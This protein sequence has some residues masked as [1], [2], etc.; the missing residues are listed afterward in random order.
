MGSFALTSRRETR[1]PLAG[2]YAAAVGLALLALCPFIVLSTAGQ[3]LNEHV[4]ADLHTS[5]FGVQLADGLANDRP[6]TAFGGEKASGLGRFGGDWAIE[7]FTTDHWISVQH[8]ART[9]P[10]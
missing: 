6:N 2:N 10:F 1:R 9:Y 7:E 3:L 5:M 8:T 4:L